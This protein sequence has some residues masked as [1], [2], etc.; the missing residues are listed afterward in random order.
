[1]KGEHELTEKLKIGA[2][3]YFVCYFQNNEKDEFLL[4]LNH[5]YEK[6]TNF[7]AKFRK[8]KANEKEDMKPEKSTHYE[9]CLSALHILSFPWI[10]AQENMISLIDLVT[11]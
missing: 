9:Q 1:L 7:I 2:A 5:K 10:I 4:K 6:L 11:A 3:A 8:V